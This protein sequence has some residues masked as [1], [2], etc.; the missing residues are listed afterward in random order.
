[1]Y[2]LK[3]QIDDILAAGAPEKY[4][5]LKILLPNRNYRKYFSKLK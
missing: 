5:I 3:V 2:T 1:M 4:W